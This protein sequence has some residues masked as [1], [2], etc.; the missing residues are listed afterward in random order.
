M[1]AER[2]CRAR[3]AGASWLHLNGD[4]KV[5]AGM[6]A[7]ELQRVV[8]LK[9]SVKRIHHMGCVPQVGDGVG[10]GD[11]ML[12]AA[13]GDASDAFITVEPGQKRLVG[14]GLVV[15]VEK[16]EVG[17]FLFDLAEM[18]EKGVTL[19]DGAG[20]IDASQG[21]EVCVML[22]N[23]SS[24][25]CRLHNGDPIAGGVFLEPFAARF[26]DVEEIGSDQAKA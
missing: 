15:S 4:A 11:F 25:A 24:K 9:V 5:V 13:V 20:L 3:G 12:R 10:A 6:G 14:T 21:G 26:F 1:E 18:A 19:A 2:G 22:H 17:L 7:G 8:D 23:R 16:P